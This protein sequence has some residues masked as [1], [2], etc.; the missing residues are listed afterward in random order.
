M[1]T[2]CCIAAGVHADAFLYESSGP[3]TCD[4]MPVLASTDDAILFERSGSDDFVP[5]PTAPISMSSSSSRLIE[6]F[7]AR[8]QN[9]STA[10]LMVALGLQLMMGKH[11]VPKAERLLDIVC[12]LIL[13]LSSKQTS[14]KTLRNILWC[15]PMDAA[16]ESAAPLVL[17]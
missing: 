7:K 12:S 10:L 17:P 14:E 15:P 3:P 11:L 6:V 5:G 13:L 1:I 16:G 8:C 9:V 2:D 4:D